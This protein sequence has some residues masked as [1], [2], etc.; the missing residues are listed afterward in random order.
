MIDHAKWKHAGRVFSLR[1]VLEKEVN[2]ASL[3]GK[4]NETNFFLKLWS[5]DLWP[6]CHSKANN[7]VSVLHKA[8]WF[9]CPVIM[10]L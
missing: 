10:G 3:F 6:L 4:G 2:D 1:N 5:N 9:P 7:N 8:A